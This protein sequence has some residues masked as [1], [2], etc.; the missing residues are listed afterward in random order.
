MQNY[1]CSNV[2]YSVIKMAEDSGYTSL[3]HHIDVNFFKAMIKSDI[4]KLINTYGHKNCGL[5]HEELC[6]EIRKIITDNKRIVF[7]YMCI[8]APPPIFQFYA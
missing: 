3:T 2:S 1:M 6:D 5:R 8:E 4:I 7:Q